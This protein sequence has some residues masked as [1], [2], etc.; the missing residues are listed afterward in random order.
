VNDKP[1]FTPGPDVTVLE[2][3]GRVTVAGWPQA[4]SPGPASEVTQRISYVVTNDNARLFAKRP[5]IAADGT[6]TFTPA[7]NANGTA[8]VTVKAR[9][10]FGTA[11]GGQNTSDPQTFQIIV[12]PVND[13]PSFTKGRDLSA[14]QG[15]GEQVIAAWAKRI[16]AGPSD[17][18]GQSL[19]FVVQQVTTPDL[20]SV[21]PAIAPDGTLTF[22]P[23]AGATGKATVTVALQDDGGTENGGMDTSPAQTFAITITPSRSTASGGTSSVSGSSGA[24]SDAA[25]LAVLADW[26]AASREERK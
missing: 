11:Y 2:D 13:A 8:A 25:L 9:D 3:S 15:A 12:T 14:A 23:A 18:T 5:A 4:V 21:L 19:A 20:F 22:T 1:S 26:Q 6:L 16:A 7:K 24:A 10:T 17:E